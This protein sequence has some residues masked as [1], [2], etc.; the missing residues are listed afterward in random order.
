MAACEAQDL[1]AAQLAVQTRGFPCTRTM[2]QRAL[3]LACHGVAVKEEM[4]AWL[5]QQ[6][7]VF[8][9]DAKEEGCGMLALNTAVQSG[10]EAIVRLLL[11]HG[12]AP[13]GADME[14]VSKPIKRML[15]AAER[16]W[17]PPIV[18][19]AGKLTM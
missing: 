4:V 2:Q 17:H 13:G 18:P 3:V 9:D 15:V 19:G 8:D 1:G 7:L 10:D 16:V 6:P 12:I 11:R 5:L 14:G